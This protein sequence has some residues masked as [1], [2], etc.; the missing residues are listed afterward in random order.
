MEPI[1]TALVVMVTAG[2]LGWTLYAFLQDLW[3]RDRHK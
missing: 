2:L 3:P 1:V